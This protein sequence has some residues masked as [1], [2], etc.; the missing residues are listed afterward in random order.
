MFKQKNIFSKGFEWKSGIDSQN[1]TIHRIL[2]ESKECFICCNIPRSTQILTDRIRTC[3]ITISQYLFCFHL[4][5]W[6]AIVNNGIHYSQMPRKKNNLSEK[7]ADKMLY[8]TSNEE[9]MIIIIKK[10][11]P[12]MTAKYM[13]YIVL[14]IVTNNGCS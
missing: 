4:T 9:G 1:R 12:L 14:S 7:E 10:T 5:H 13:R 11:F 3:S 2:K 6:D 8:K